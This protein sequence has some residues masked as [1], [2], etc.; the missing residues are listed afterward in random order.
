[1]PRDVEGIAAMRKSGRVRLK[2]LRRAYR[3]IHDC[4]DAGH[5]HRAWP[6]ILAEGLARLVDGQVVVMGEISFGEHGVPAT[7]RSLAQR[8]WQ[9]PSDREHYFQKFIVDKDFGDVLTFQRFAALRGGLITRTREQ[10]ITNDDWYGSQEFNEYNRSWMVDDMIMSQTMFGDPPTLLGF[11]ISGDLSRERFSRGE[12]RL[13][14]MFHLEIA[15]H[16]GSSLAREP[17]HPLPDLPPRL[18]ET[19]ECL[20]EG[21]SEKQAARRLGLSRHTVHQYVQDLYRR[22]GVGTRAE[23]MALCLRRPTPRPPDRSA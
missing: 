17:D 7:V 2:D 19:L 6:S 4:R 5:D 21:D 8:G 11:T 20:L 18:K 12:R 10:L 22:L 13:I 9:R 15:G 23:L 3:L 14:R 1:M 16:I